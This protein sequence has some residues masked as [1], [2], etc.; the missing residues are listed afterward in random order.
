MVG[1]VELE[2]VGSQGQAVWSVGSQALTLHLV[3]SQRL[4]LDS[5]ISPFK[6]STLAL[7]SAASAGSL[8][9]TRMRFAA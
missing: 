8:F 4:R 5:N 3:M 9:L 2:P 6:K 7:E 1:A